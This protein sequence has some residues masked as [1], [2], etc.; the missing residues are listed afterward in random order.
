MLKGTTG[1]LK[2]KEKNSNKDG[3]DGEKHEKKTNSVKFVNRKPN[4]M[5]GEMEARAERCSEKRQKTQKET[6]GGGV[7]L[8]EEEYLLRRR[9]IS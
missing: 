2:R 9:S 4:S 6:G 3:G 7:S 5:S 1:V 8:E